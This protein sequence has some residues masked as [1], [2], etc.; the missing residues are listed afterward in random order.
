M[1]SIL[2]VLAVVTACGDHEGRADEPSGG[3]ATFGGDE[4]SSSSAGSE[5]DDGSTVPPPPTSCGNGGW[6]CVASAPPGWSGPFVIFDGDPAD[7]PTCDGEPALTAHADLQAPA[8]AQCEPCSCGEATGD[9]CGPVSITTYAMSE[10]GTCGGCS[11]VHD[12]APGECATGIAACGQALGS[13]E[14]EAPW[15]SGGSC[16]PSSPEPVLPELAW[17]RAAIGCSASVDVPGCAA[18]ETCMPVAAAPF[19]AETACIAHDGDVPCPDSSWSDRRVFHRGADDQRGCN[20]CECGESQ[21]A[22]CHG[23]LELYADDACSQVVVASYGVPAD[24]TWKS[25]YTAVGV[26]L[27][28]PFGGACEPSGGGPTGTATA[29]DPVTVCCAAA[30]DPDAG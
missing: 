24:C 10:P 11:E 16:A 23:T 15:A 14:I 3:I 28:A 4:S 12:V 9:V 6:K 26:T 22:T 8:D 13:I 5:S 18:D 25:S 29:N 30:M 20:A 27:D 7:A 21:G 2:C 17:S 1:R 19:E